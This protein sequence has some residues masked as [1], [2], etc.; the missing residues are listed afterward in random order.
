MTIRGALKLPFALDGEEKMD[1]EYCDNH[2][3]LVTEINYLK[4][5]TKDI[6]T[7]ISKMREEVR[8]LSTHEKVY[9]AFI[10]FAG[11]ALSAGGSVLGTLIVGFFK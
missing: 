11:I 2:S 5:D 8:N 6:K 3:C 7:E 9:I 10:G 1:K 4:E